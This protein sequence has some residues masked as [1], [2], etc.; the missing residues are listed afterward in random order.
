MTYKADITAL[1]M[2]VSALM[3]THPDRKA[4]VRALESATGTFQLAAL[5]ARVDEPTKNEV[6]TIVSRW[7]AGLE[8]SG[9]AG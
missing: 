1:H 4:L 7:I 9:T 8:G 6:R 2:A 5:A 3:D